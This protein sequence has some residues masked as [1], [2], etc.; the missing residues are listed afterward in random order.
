MQ[1]GSALL[2]A[3]VTSRTLNCS[4]L[5]RLGNVEHSDCNRL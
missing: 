1:I 5:W 2:R 4:R 3:L